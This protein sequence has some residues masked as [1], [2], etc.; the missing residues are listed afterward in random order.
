[1][2]DQIIYGGWKE[3]SDYTKSNKIKHISFDFWNTIAFGNPKFKTERTN[4]IFE[5][6]GQNVS[7]QKISEAF[8]S[9]GSSYNL[10]FENGGATLSIEELYMQVLKTLGEN[11]FNEINSLQ[12]QVF[13][14]FL[15]FPPNISNEF[16]NFLKTLKSEN[17]TCSITSNTTFIPGEVIQKF[18][19]HS[20]LLQYFSF[21]HFSDIEHVAKPNKELFQKLISRTASIVPETQDILHI[22][23]NLQ[24]DYYGAIACDLKAFHFIDSANKLTNKRFALYTIDNTDKLPFSEIEYSKFK[25]GDHSI[26]EKYGDDLFEYFKN[27]HLPSVINQSKNILIYSS[28]Y[29]HI[30]TSSY[31]LTQSFYRALTEYTVSNRLL[32]IKIR[33]AKIQRCQTYTDD[34]GSMTA[35][36]RFN[37]IKNDTYELIDKPSKEDLCIFIDD[38]SI[39][40]T[41]QKVVEHLLVQNAIETNSIFLYLAKLSNPT[42]HPAFENRLNY[43]YINNITK[44]TELTISQEYKITTR[45]TKYLLSIGANDFKY[46]ID[47]MILNNKLTVLEELVIMSNANEYNK[48][49]LYQKNLEQLSTVIPFLKRS[50][51]NCNLKISFKQ[52]H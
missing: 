37:L 27:E 43:A 18:L 51:D 15:A 3:I 12:N 31:Y 20:N 47:Q 14:L 35:E 2:T 6:L 40:G 45:A 34:Y 25:Y 19:N 5:L 29:A 42:I 1:M 21:C 30:P 9:I 36:E 44:L 49:E 10:S 46:F 17:I 52:F 11:D 4:L 22:G 23:D 28:P 32:D 24:A 41:H 8:T 13:D 38:I 39:T 48:I 33:F 50:T 26:A 16:L 7:K